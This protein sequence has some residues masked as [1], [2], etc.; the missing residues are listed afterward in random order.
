MYLLS[1]FDSTYITLTA[2]NSKTFL[3]ILLPK[4]AHK[5]CAFYA[6][7]RTI[8][9]PISVLSGKTKSANTTILCGCFHI[10]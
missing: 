7:F 6:V 10:I 3:I 5:I 2:Q 8:F 1:F 4:C 9:L